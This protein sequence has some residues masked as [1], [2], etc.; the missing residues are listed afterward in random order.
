MANL[1]HQVVD[2]VLQIIYP[3]P[4][5]VNSGDYLVGHRLEPGNQDEDKPLKRALPVLHLLKHILDVVGQ[6]SHIFWI[7]LDSNCS[8]LLPFSILSTSL[9]A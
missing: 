7:L 6:L 5:V 3:R 9:A 1:C 2:I 8:V 4:H